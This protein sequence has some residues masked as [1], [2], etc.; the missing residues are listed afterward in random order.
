M[1]DVYHEVTL[2]HKSGKGWNRG[3]D[4]APRC[5]HAASQVSE[6]RNSDA[7]QLTKQLIN[8]S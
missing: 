3:Y 4:N 2:F 1:P 8:L 5:E 6:L 7:L